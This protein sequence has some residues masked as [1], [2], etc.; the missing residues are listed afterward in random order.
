MWRRATDLFTG[1][2]S[3][4]SC[5]QFVQIHQNTDQAHYAT[6]HD[7]IDK[8]K[9]RAKKNNMFVYIII[10]QVPF[11]VSYKGNK[12][13]NIEDVDRFNL[14]F[15][16][17][18]YHDKNWTWLDLV[19]AI[20]QRCK[21]VLLQQF[22]TQKLLRNRIM[23]VERVV[24]ANVEPIDEEEK[25]RIVLGTTTILDK[26]KR[27]K[28]SK[29]MSQSQRS[30]S[31]FGSGK[32]DKR[33]RKQKAHPIWRKFLITSTDI[34]C[35][36][37]GCRKTLKLHGQ[38]RNLL[39]FELLN[40]PISLIDEEETESAPLTGLAKLLAKASGKKRAAK[41]TNCALNIESIKADLKEVGERLEVQ[42]PIGYWDSAL[43]TIFCLLATLAMEIL[44]IPTTSAP[45][46]RVF[47]QADL[48]TSRHRS[49]TEILLL[50]SQVYLEDWELVN[51][52]ADDNTAAV[53][54]KLKELK[55]KLTGR[56]R[57]L[58][59]VES[60]GFAHGF[61]FSKELAICESEG[62]TGAMDEGMKAS[63]MIELPLDTT[64]WTCSLMSNSRLLLLRSNPSESST[65]V[66][67]TS[68]KDDNMVNGDFD[69]DYDPV[70]DAKLVAKNAN[71]LMKND[72]QIMKYWFQR[73][74]LF[75]KLNDG[76]LM[77]REGWFSVTPERI[78]EHIADRMARENGSII[79]DAFTGISTSF[80]T[81][82]IL[83]Y[84]YYFGCWCNAIQFALRGAHVYAIDIDPVRLR[85][86]ARNA[87]IYGVSKQITFICG[88]FFN[89]AKSFFGSRGLAQA[90]DSSGDH[91]SENIYGI[92]SVF[93]SP[94]W[95]DHHIITQ[96]CSIWSFMSSQMARKFMMYR[97]E[98]L[99]IFAIFCRRIP[100]LIS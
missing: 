24:G 59:K 57:F 56:Q 27:K 100:L 38:P 67:N 71:K 58:L 28:L 76:V 37:E 73:Y 55:V 3:T 53:V 23:G 70:R 7:E 65:T 21:R 16:I 95:G 98:S 45:I 5:D 20:K 25:K 66:S 90:A 12:E 6:I 4:R 1:Q 83:H 75:S 69:F 68:S 96:R 36:V 43:N 50:N 47:S 40:C 52:G 8:M 35:S 9:E 84:L 22:M 81:P 46:E 34:K 62:D 32:I 78:A 26:S 91:G 17:F 10:P 48:A 30:S 2:K 74:R 42:N 72:Q 14:T 63:R 54:E 41:S 93:L 80:S 86:A 79:L 13:K 94:P 51:L 19:L 15:P 82:F 60:L 88:D 11:V 29:K 33:A 31:S 18:E 89:I 99:S 64:T 85:C 44:A 39:S 92:S 61:N 97:V 87:E 77:D 49:R